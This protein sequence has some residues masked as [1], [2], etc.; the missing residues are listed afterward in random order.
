MM[1][2]GG[3]IDSSLKAR[4]IRRPLWSCVSPRSR[5]A[6]LTWAM[7]CPI[8]RIDVLGA[9]GTG[10]A[11]MEVLRT[12]FGDCFAWLLF[13]VLRSMPTPAVLATFPSPGN[14]AVW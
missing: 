13:R 3:A 8:A 6:S 12:V 10:S 4:G 11:A 7:G 1:F 14:V 5:L 9:F 2:A